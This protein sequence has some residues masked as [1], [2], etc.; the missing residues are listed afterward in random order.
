MNN[1]KTFPGG[2]VFSF[3]YFVVYPNSTH[4]F[5][6]VHKKFSKL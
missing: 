2:K 3:Q 1:D 4:N 5:A 6:L